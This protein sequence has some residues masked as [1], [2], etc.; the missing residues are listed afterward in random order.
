MNKHQEL[1]GFFAR[2]FDVFCCHDWIVFPS[3]PLYWDNVK[4][5]HTYIYICIYIYSIEQTPFHVLLLNGILK[6]MVR[7]FFHSKLECSC[8][9]SLCHFTSWY[10]QNRMSVQ[11]LLLIEDRVT[12]VLMILMF[13]CLQFSAAAKRTRRPCQRICPAQGCSVAGHR[14]RYSSVGEL[15]WWHNGDI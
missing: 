11:M 3:K 15:A 8:V 10:H 5:Q 9:I 13:S 7:L 12:F 1:P 2:F 6:R 14:I 4:W